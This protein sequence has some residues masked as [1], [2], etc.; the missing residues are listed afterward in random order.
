MP[1]NP[2]VALVTG[3]A[4]G[5]GRACGVALAREGYAVVLAG[6]DYQSLGAVADEIRSSGA[7]P[8]P[9]NATSKRRTR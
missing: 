6:R 2:R 4:R 9:F 8:K 5:I 7:R 3:A 1:S